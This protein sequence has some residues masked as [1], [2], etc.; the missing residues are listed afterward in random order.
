MST[1]NSLGV[2][3]GLTLPTGG[4]SGAIVLAV[5][6]FDY[7]P[8]IACAVSPSQGQFHNVETAYPQATCALP[9]P[10]LARAREGRALGGLSVLPAAVPAEVL[11]DRFR[12]CRDDHRRRE[13]CRQI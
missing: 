4:A 13:R 11:R 5:I 8:D 1:T 6:C 12:R 7:G 10:R 3:R 2:V 9:A